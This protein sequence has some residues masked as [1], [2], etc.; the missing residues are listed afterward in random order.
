MNSWKRYWRRLGKC[1]DMGYIYC[2]ENNSFLK[3][4]EEK[5]ELPQIVWHI[6]D[7]CRLKCRYCFATKSNMEVD[8]TRIDDYI[9]RFKELGIQKIDISGGEP[10]EYDHLPEICESL[11]QNGFHITLTTKG[12]G[13]NKNIQWLEDAGSMFSRIIFSID[14][15]T[16]SGQ[17]LMVGTKDDTF[18][19]ITEIM[20]CLSEK[21]YKDTRVNTVVTPDLMSGD[22][23]DQM[24]EL[25]NT[26]DC[27]E[28]CLIQP[29]PANKKE[30]FEEISVASQEFNKVIGNVKSRNIYKG[31]L[32]Y[33]YAE[34]YRDYW[35]LYPD[36]KLSKH[37]IGQ[38]D[39]YN[40]DLLNTPVS[41]ILP[42]VINHTVWVQE[43]K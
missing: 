21:D 6:T 43:E 13:Q 40:F 22:S 5:N 39:I 12:I 16:K 32:L 26:L 25:M 36:G 35:V 1:V 33:R 31:T 29:H 8:S 23:I 15:P 27:R 30:T 11:Y 38:H 19:R 24:A 4:K 41:F 7:K 17:A 3:T 9:T 14:L 42:E 20:K 28:W 34:N 10:L 18:G 37:T 2:K